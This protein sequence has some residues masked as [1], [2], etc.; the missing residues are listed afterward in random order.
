MKK[1]FIR[2][3]GWCHAIDNI[4]NGLVKQKNKLTIII[5]LHLKIAKNS[6]KN[7][8]GFNYLHEI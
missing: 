8:M 3:L 4:V 6:F 1:M 5:F 2:M 7:N